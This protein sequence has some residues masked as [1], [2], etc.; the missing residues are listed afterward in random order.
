VAA[1]SLI[2]VSFVGSV[3]WFVSAEGAAV[4]YGSQGWNPVVV[5]LL[6]ASGQGAMH[7]LL[8]LGG[9]RLIRRSAWL[10]RQVART[11]ERYQAHLDTHYLALS[12][13]G[14]LAGIPP[15]VAMS[16]LAAG[17]GLKISRYLPVLLAGR[18]AR[19]ALLSAFGESLGTWIH[20]ALPW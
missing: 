16:L 10:T 5:G 8:Y 12:L 18:L 17:F 15:L 20:A 13:L 6:C 1:L 4:L 11:R 14:A 2:L 9:E 7:L 3:F 19:F